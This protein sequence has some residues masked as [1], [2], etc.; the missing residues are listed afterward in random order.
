MLYYYFRTDSFLF[1]FMNF[2]WVILKCKSFWLI[3]GKN[4]SFDKNKSTYF[5]TWTGF[6]FCKIQSIFSKKKHFNW[7]FKFIFSFFLNIF[8]IVTSLIPF[9]LIIIFLFSQMQS[10]SFWQWDQ[11]FF[12][13]GIR[14][15]LTWG[16]NFQ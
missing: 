15:F 3:C 14:V 1:I 6:I 13:L 16:W 7:A 8:Y 5:K 11:L 12:C 2:L 9:I 4:I 10:N